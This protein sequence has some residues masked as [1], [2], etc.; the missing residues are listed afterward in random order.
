M[1]WEVVAPLFLKA[2]QHGERNGSYARA[3]ISRASL[4]QVVAQFPQESFE[5]VGGQK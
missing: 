3:V 5:I 1:Q 4:T 2:D